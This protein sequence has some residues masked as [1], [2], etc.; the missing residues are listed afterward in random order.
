MLLLISIIL[1][2]SF[3]ASAAEIIVARPGAADAM[4]LEACVLQ[5]LKSNDLLSAE[6]MRRRELDG[7]MKQALA[8]GLPTLD[9]SGNWMRSRDPSFAL[10]STFGGSD[11][12]SMGSAALDSLFSGFSF[13]PSPEDI[14]AQTYWRTSLNMHWELNPIRIMGAVGAANAGIERQDQAVIG[15]TQQTEESVIKAYHGIIL[16]YEQLAS[17][18][19]NLTSQR[20]LLD[21][22]QMRFERG[23]AT[24][25]DTLQAAVTVAN[26]E[27]Q[28]RLARQGLQVAGSVLNAAMGRAAD[29]PVS[30]FADQ[31]IEL[32]AIDGDAALG[33]AMTRPDIQM[34]S[35]L[36]KLLQQNRK[37]QKANLMPYFSADASYGLV[38]KE[39]QDLNDTGHD[40]WSATVSLTVPI[41]DGLLHRGSMQETGASILRNEAELSGLKRQIRVEVLDLLSRLDAARQNLAAADLNLKR[42]DDL[43]ET[44]KLMLRVGKTDYLNVLDAEANRSLANANLIQARFDVLTQTASLKRAIGVSPMTPLAFIEGL[45]RGEDND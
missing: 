36:T 22:Q 5:A 12:G 6:R 42:S 41:F 3:A 44:S 33:M 31:P 43:L 45:S 21:I 32:D 28:V 27:P 14:P 37:A 7:Q 18:Q 39:I 25:L 29:M 38:G 40:F 26:L 15:V 2:T 19:A 35:Y 8:T 4:D 13:L 16:A 30:V 24:E 1:T 9:A 34:M 10:D 23:M 17:A 11:G 20:E